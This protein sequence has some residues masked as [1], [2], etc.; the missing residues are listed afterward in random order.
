M[1]KFWFQVRYTF[2]KAL[3]QNQRSSSDTALN[4]SILMI[5]IPMHVLG[6]YS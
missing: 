2:A 1:V 4:S 6:N 3:G 5:Q